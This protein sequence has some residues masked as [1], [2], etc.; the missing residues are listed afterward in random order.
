MHS[1]IENHWSTV[2][3]ILR[4]LNGTSTYGLHIH[5]NSGT[6]FHSYADSTFTNISVISDAGWV[7]CLYDRRS[8]RGY[9]IYRIESHLLVC[10][11][12]KDYITFI[13]QI[14]IQSLTD[15]IVELI[16][17]QTLL[18]ELRVLR[19]RTLKLW[20]DNLGVT[21]LSGNLEFHMRRK[22]MLDVDFHFVREKVAQKNMFVKFIFQRWQDCTHL[23]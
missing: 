3:Y 16:W 14:W 22:N 23:H 5:Q 18:H 12:A 19:K 6:S 8:T 21:Y 10:K 2:K 7:S 1:L 11:K 13:N 9:T 4:Y 17:L 15:I 20:N